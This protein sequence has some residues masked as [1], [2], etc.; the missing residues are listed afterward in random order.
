MKKVFAICLAL[1]MVLSLSVNVMAAPNFVESPT[2]NRAPIIVDCENEDEDCTASIVVTPF[3]DRDT[4]SDEHKQELQD[5]YDQIVNSD[6]LTDMFSG[7]EDLLLPGM[8]ETDLSISDLFHIYYDNCENHPTHG[9]F[10]IT[11]STDT[12]QGFVGLIQFVDGEWQ[13]VTDAKV[14]GNHLSFTSDKLSAYAIVVDRTKA[15]STSPVTGA[16]T[17][18]YLTAAVV[19]AGLGLAVVAVVTAKK[20]A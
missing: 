18:S 19:F 8:L 17:A 13:I 2:G 5:A 10:D 1:M 20:K 11:L 12:L 7:I 3:G 9:K 15:E 6:K 16:P 4:L 14:E